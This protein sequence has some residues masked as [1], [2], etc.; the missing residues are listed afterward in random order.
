[1]VAAW[2]TVTILA[3]DRRLMSNAFTSSSPSQFSYSKALAAAAAIEAAGGTP[4]NFTANTQ[5]PTW[6]PGTSTGV[7]APSN[8]STGQ[9]LLPNWLIPIAGIAVT[10]VLANTFDWLYKPI[11]F[12]L[13]G[14]II[15]WI[16]NG[17]TS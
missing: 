15:L 13:I 7:I 10:V 17:Q 3:G 14:I 5:N 11:M 16:L 9:G 8:V 1:M 12:G 6:Y 4:P 2:K